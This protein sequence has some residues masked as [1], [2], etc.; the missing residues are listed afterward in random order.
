[1]KW[2]RAIESGEFSNTP[3]I[4]NAWQAQTP[5]DTLSGLWYGCG[6]FVQTNRRLQKRLFITRDLMEGFARSYS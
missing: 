3:M 5:V 2:C 4:R 6:W 1:M